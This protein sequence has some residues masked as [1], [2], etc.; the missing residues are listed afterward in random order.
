M[1]KKKVISSQEPYTNKVFQTLWFL[2]A[3]EQKRL[4]K[5]LHSPY[6]NQSKTLIALCEVLLRHVE[7]GKQGFDRESVWRKIFPREPYDDVNFRKYCSDLLKQVEGFMAQ[8]S[9]ESDKARKSIDLLDFVARRKVEPLFNSVIRQSRLELGQLPYHPLDYYMKA[10]AIERHYYAL[11]DFDVKVNVR[12]N[13]EEISYN[14]DIFYWIEK[15][16]LYSSVLSQKRTGNFNYE[17]N[18]TDEILTFLQTFPIEDVPEL[19]I[20]YYSFLTLQDEENV[21]HYY[22]LRRMLD[23]FG[24]TMPKKEAM[25]LYDS[26]LHYCTGKLNRG[27]RVF[28]QEYFDLFEDA[29]HKD[30][31]LQ[32]G[33]LAQWRYNNII[34]VALRLGKLDWAE[35][36]VENY[37]SYLNQNTREN[38]Y[39]FNLARVYRYQKK[40]NK[41]LVLLQSVDYEDII[42]NLISKAMLVITYYELDE[43]DT[44][45]SFL[46]SFR[47]FLNRN[48]NVP[49]RKNHLNL[50]KYTRRLTRLAP[51]DKAAIQKL[52]EEINLERA[53]TVNHEWLLEKLDELG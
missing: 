52:R 45:D 4:L 41:V 22:N 53:V 8:E 25:E 28:L 36:F 6:F 16:K 24:A 44:L 42:Y 35:K 7:A 15:L 1:P 38:T 26:A 21:E 18:L 13:I 10:Y 48:K 3:G 30:I 34:G 39:T 46:E 47:V 40:F 50:I 19:A 32:K 5:Y 29:I 9:I 17:L 12:A 31:F 33:E 14:L 23:K 37:K 2:D 51:G 20:Y 11:M 43:V 49:Y 27:N